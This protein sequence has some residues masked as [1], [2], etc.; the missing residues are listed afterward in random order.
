M[1]LQIFF[2]SYFLIPTA[3]QWLLTIF[4]ADYIPR[5][6]FS[7][8]HHFLPFVR[9]FLL[10]FPPTVMHE[11]DNLFLMFWLPDEFFH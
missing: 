3:A 1:Y 10:Q 6:S 8:V 2:S 4:E 11:A 7:R 9:P 5:R